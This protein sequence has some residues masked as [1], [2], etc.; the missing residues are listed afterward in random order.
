MK[1]LKGDEYPYH[2]GCISCINHNKADC[3]KCCYF[4]CDWK[5]KN[6][7]IRNKQHLGKLLDKKRS[8]R[9]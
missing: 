8:K 2:G 6:L 4:N 9:K 5:M 7:N 3:I 1:N